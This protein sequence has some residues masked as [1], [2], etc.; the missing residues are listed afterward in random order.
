MRLDTAS[1]SSKLLNLKSQILI[2]LNSHFLRSLSS[3]VKALSTNLHF[4][5]AQEKSQ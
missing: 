1:T 3:K 2:L 5:T 4:Y